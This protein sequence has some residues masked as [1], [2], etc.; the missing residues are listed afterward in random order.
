[1]YNY[2]TSSNN[3]PLKNHVFFCVCIQVIY[4]NSF[5]GRSQI[6]SPQNKSKK[7][8]LHKKTGY[9]TAIVE[10]IKFKAIGISR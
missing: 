3:N 10:Q 1:M 2:S 5:K 4:N 8:K 7:A 9:I 6:Y